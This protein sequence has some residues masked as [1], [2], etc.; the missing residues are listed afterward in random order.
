MNLPAL[1]RFVRAVD[2]VVELWTGFHDNGKERF[3]VAMDQLAKEFL[4]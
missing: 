3:R 2:N 4:K 1:L